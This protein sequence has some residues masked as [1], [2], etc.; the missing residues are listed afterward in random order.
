MLIIFNDAMQRSVP[1]IS[2]QLWK[3][4]LSLFTLDI[5]WLYELAP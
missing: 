1:L 4:D 5:P 2:W 3:A